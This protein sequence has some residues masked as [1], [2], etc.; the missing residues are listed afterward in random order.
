MHYK[1]E[2]VNGNTYYRYEYSFLKDFITKGKRDGNVGMIPISEIGQFI[3]YKGFGTIENP[4]KSINTLSLTK[5]PLFDDP[6]MDRTEPMVSYKYELIDLS[7]YN[8]RENE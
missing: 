1:K 7:K 6:Y 3:K 5:L 4:F 2:V 8:T